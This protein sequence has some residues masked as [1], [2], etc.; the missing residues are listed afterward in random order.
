[1]R[2]KHFLLNNLLLAAA[3]QHCEW[4][5]K[6]AN[7]L[8]VQTDSGTYRGIINGSAP[9]VREFLGIPFAKPPQGDRTYTYGQ[10][11]AND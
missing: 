10:Q 4:P 1:M 2:I 5:S 3:S 6:P 7:Y 9:L 8:I 11:P